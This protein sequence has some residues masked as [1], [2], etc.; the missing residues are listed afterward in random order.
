MSKK[1]T[2][3]YKTLY[4][5]DLS[6]IRAIHPDENSFTH[7]FFFERDSEGIIETVGISIFSKYFIRYE[8]KIFVKDKI[9]ENSYI[10]SS[11]LEK[12][13]AKKCL[14]YQ[15]N[16]AIESGYKYIELIADRCDHEYYEED[17]KIPPLIGYKIWGKYGF[18]MVDAKERIDFVKIMLNHNFN[19]LLIC[20]IYEQTQEGKNAREKW[21][22][23]GRMWKGRFTL[24]ID[25]LSYKILKAHPNWKRFL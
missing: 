20:D 4:L 3:V 8:V 21:A 19:Y 14:D 22:D 6:G 25:C 18:L 24:E 13:V 1:I 11:M 2:D 9:I 16:K 12:G 17:Q 23:K 5:L 7:E 10:V 15:V